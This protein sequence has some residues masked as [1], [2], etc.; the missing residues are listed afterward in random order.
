MGEKFKDKILYLKLKQKDQEAF[1]EAYD[2]YVNDIYRFVF[3]KVNIKEE[4]EDI[5]SS[6]FLKTWDYIQNNSITD[7]KTLKSLFYKV[8]RN[9]IIDYYRKKNVT[10]SIDKIND[11]KGIDVADE[12]QDIHK[13]LEIEGEIKDVKA[14][15]LELKDEYREIITLRFINDLSIDEIAKILDKDKGNIRVLIHRAIQALKKIL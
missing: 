3:F 11:E 10:I 12:S 15:M 13:Q 2:K 14:G 9:A 7:Y 1:I 4:A 6:I 5:T 8:A